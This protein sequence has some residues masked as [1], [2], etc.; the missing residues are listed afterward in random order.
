MARPQAVKDIQDPRLVKALSHPIRVHILELMSEGEHSPSSLAPVVG[1]PLANCAY[2]VGVLKK[3]N[4]IKEVRQVP[5][6]GAIEH[7]YVAVPAAVTSRAWRQMPDVV[8]NNFVGTGLTELVTLASDA[9][10]AGGFNGKHH[11]LSR[12][13]VAL[14]E[15]GLAA[16]DRA[17][18]QFLAAVDKIEPA[19]NGDGAPVVIG[20]MVFERREPKPQPRRGRGLAVGP[21]K[22]RQRRPRA[23]AS[24]RTS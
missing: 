18:D 6:R 11:S 24:S 5:H 19:Q 9:A 10:G 17:H 12:R 15:K 23:T 16:L 4:L 22:P 2:H 20:T 14:D 3:L 21:R 8:R 7:R 13:T 1:A